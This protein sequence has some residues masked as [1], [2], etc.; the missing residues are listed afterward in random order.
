MRNRSAALIYASLNVVSLHVLKMTQRFLII[1]CGSGFGNRISSLL[2]ALAVAGRY[3]LQPVVDWSDP[4]YS[5]DGE[6]VFRRYFRLNFWKSELDVTSLPATKV[7]PSAWGG[8]LGLTSCQL[9]QRF[10]VPCKDQQFLLHRLVWH[11]RKSECLVY[12]GFHFERRS[13]FKLGIIASQKKLFHKH[14]LPSEELR[15]WVDR[16]PS[17]Q[18]YVGMHVRST[19]LGTKYEL[20]DFLK[21]LTAAESRKVLLCTDSAEVESEM[22]KLLGDGVLTVPKWLPERSD[23]IHTFDKKSV[24]VDAVMTGFEALRDLYA[25]SS[26]KRVI[27]TYGSTF[28]YLAARVVASVPRKLTVV[29]RV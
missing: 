7:T 20:T 12:T 21:T 15:V 14:L 23:A 22:C 3:G 17:L 28:S 5:N 10:G 2:G 19:D 4:C 11:G 8:R 6:N 27:G 13:L 1:K 9:M 25:L 18:D 26:C 24:G 29:G 16:L